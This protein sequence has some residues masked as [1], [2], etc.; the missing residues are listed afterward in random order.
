MGGS[1]RSFPFLAFF[2]GGIVSGLSDCMRVREG[3][4]KGGGGRCK[5]GTFVRRTPAATYAVD[6]GSEIWIDAN[7]ATLSWR[8]ST[9]PTLGFDSSFMHCRIAESSSKNKCLVHQAEKPVMISRDINI[10]AG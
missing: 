6:L 5:E 7:L 8:V 1:A 10:A 9:Q 2:L 4:S 3:Y